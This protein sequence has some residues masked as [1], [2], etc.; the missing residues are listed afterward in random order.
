MT[1]AN[2]NESTEVEET[3]EVLVTSEMVM[4]QLQEV[5]G[6]TAMQLQQGVINPI[7]LARFIGCRP[8]QVYGDIRSGRLVG[9][10]DNNTQKLYVE[11]HQAVEYAAKR[12][13][14]RARAQVR[15][16][17][18]ARLDE[19]RAEALAEDAS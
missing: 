4:Q 2:T 13:D 18:Q 5:E 7:M 10:K 1:E 9:V 14:R 6:R 12:L 8:Q 16:E 11:I 15:A 19:I 3:E 17:L